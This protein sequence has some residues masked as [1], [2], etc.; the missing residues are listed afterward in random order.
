METVKYALCLNI[1][2]DKIEKAGQEIQTLF[3]SWSQQIET[4][5]WQ[6]NGPAKVVLDFDTETGEFDFDTG[7]EHD[8]PIWLRDDTL[9]ALRDIGRY[10][11]SG[12]IVHRTINGKQ[13]DFAVGPS[14]LAMKQATQSERIH[15]AL[16]ALANIR[17][18]VPEDVL[19][20]IDNLSAS[21]KQLIQ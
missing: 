19:T 3:K 20:D 13:A 14:D 16:E 2:Q 7:G 5:G 15:R 10:A 1:K 21:L 12:A 11:T 17:D 9:A 8:I 6:A 18:A 4:N